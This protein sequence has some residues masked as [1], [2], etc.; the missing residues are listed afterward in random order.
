MHIGGKEERNILR[1]VV[2]FRMYQFAKDENQ[3]AYTP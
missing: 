1:H 3:A 2:Q